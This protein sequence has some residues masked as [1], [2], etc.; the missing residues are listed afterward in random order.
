MR[1]H[2]YACLL[3][4]VPTT[5]AVA[6]GG[7]AAESPGDET[8]AGHGLLGN[9]A[10]DFS[11]AAVSNGKGKVALSDLR[12]KVVLVDFWATFC[13]PCKR[14]FPKLQDLYARYAS[15]GLSIVGISEDEAEDKEKIPSFGDTYGAKFTLAWDR[16]KSAARKY[17][18]ETMPSSFVIDKEGVI[19]HAHVGYHDGEEVQLEQEIKDLLAQ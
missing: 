8:P 18:P 6:C 9:P 14:S 11:V 12:G 10:P 19:R 15:R 3:G 4:L 5:S 13:E 16:T 17:K 7:G 2:R 1:I